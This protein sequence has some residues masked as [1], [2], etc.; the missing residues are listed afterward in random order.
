MTQTSNAYFPGF[1]QDTWELDVCS[2]DMGGFC[3]GIDLNAEEFALGWQVSSCQA[4]FFPGCKCCWPSGEAASHGV[5][6]EN[7]SRVMSGAWL[8]PLRVH[9]KTAFPPTRSKLPAVHL[10]PLHSRRLLGPL[11]DI[12]WRRGTYISIVITSN[13][14]RS[15]CLTIKRRQEAERILPPIRCFN[16]AGN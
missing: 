16:E 13:L 9:T 14:W 11:S 15:I 3:S 12:L 2:G 4:S 6:R 1:F 7:N 5:R 8:K 10:L